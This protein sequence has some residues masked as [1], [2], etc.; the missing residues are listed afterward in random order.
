VLL[1]IDSLAKNIIN[2]LAALLGKTMK[3]GE[4]EYYDPDKKFEGKDTGRT[5]T[6]RGIIYFG[7]KEGADI[8]VVDGDSDEN[9]YIVNGERYEPL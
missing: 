7:W 1:D 6:R 2:Q 4:K 9:G 3:Q 8:E 5:N